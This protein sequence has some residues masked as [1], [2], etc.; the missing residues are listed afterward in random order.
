M[1]V[2]HS[3]PDDATSP[4]P[5]VAHLRWPPGAFYWAIVDLTP[6]GR[7]VGTMSLRASRTGAS[8]KVHRQI[9]YL[10][11]PSLPVPLEQLHWSF[12]PLGDRQVLCCAV[13]RGRLEPLIRDHAALETLTP[14]ATPALPIDLDRPID[15]EA[16]NLLTGPFEPSRI[17][18]VR[19]MIVWQASLLIVLGIAGVG[20][21][22][23]VRASA[24]ENAIMTLE[25]TRTAR[26]VA[27]LDD[28]ESD[29]SRPSS[30]LPPE[31]R[32]L[33]ELR[34]LERASGGSTSANRR[35]DDAAP[36]LAALLAAWPE[37]S[38]ASFESL[39]VSSESIVVQGVAPEPAEAQ[40]VSDALAGLRGWRLLQPQL[41]GL[42]DSVAFTIELRRAAVGPADGA[43]G[44]PAD[45]PAARDAP[46]VTS[47]SGRAPPSIETAT[48]F[49][50]P[51][52]PARPSAA[53]RA[54]GASR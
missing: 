43:A 37:P 40:R 13:D 48:P 44:G 49:P 3:A 19:R 39:V 27:A 6:L 24:I 23:G 51:Q 5:E 42:R 30:P 52:A 31:L 26:I 7:S 41:R 29:L 12:T 53:L 36:A 47:E 17:A 20:L 32:L 16:L 4:A 14:S 9:G 11:E 45:E 34:R 50:P 35:S 28:G 46:G 15:C 2:R 54:P 21:G 22:F 8:P 38:Q 10:L 18:K 25:R 1:S 33:A